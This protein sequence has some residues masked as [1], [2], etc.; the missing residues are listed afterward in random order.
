[1]SYPLLPELRVLASAALMRRG[2]V[3]LIRCDTIKAEA[4]ARWEKI[5]GAVS[6]QLETLLRQ[7]LGP[8][9][10]FAA[11]DDTTFLVSTPSADAE[12]AQVLCL[13]VAHE[14]HTMF[15]GPC[16]IAKLRIARAVDLNG[17]KIEV[18]DLEGETLNRLAARA[19][20]ACDEEFLRARA[21]QHAGAA[22][23]ANGAQRTAFREKFAPLWDAQREAVTAWRCITL[24]RP[25]VRANDPPGMQFKLD[26]GATLS[27]IRRSADAL[28]RHLTSG[29]RFLVFATVPYEIL[30]SPIGRMEIATLCRS[31]SANLRPYLVFEIDDLPCGV[32]QSR[33][34]ELV[35]VL[36]PFC[37]AVAGQ[38]PARISSYGIYQGAGL[39][40]IGLSL[41]AGGAAA[42]EMSSEVFKLATAAKRLHI[43]SFVSDAGTDDAV[44][45]ARS[46]GV[47]YISGPVI[48]A[49][50][51]EPVSV[52]RLT[53]A[54]MCESA[55]KLEVA[56]A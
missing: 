16:K 17:D 42:T 44:S 5:G 7:K 11:L 50:Q 21:P 13:R 37:R 51:G 2:C 4:G 55:R 31:L 34:F 45:W 38:L 54:E 26:L 18:A 27:R 46:Q 23:A 49:P 43:L 30:S 14:L 10:F 28:T 39:K 52:H 40:A 12:A 41:T 48:G 33:L 15:L 35:G 32:P 22:K 36:R 3:N 9:D 24:E 20:L 1:M 29:D 53:V 6:A 25:P 8:S 19:G 47:N 56:A